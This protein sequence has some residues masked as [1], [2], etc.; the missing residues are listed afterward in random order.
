VILFILSRT[1]STVEKNTYQAKKRPRWRSKSNT[2]AAQG[3]NCG[4]LAENRSAV[5]KL[6]S[7][8]GDFWGAVCGLFVLTAEESI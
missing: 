6:V 8:S 7:V 5:R 4:F 1:D 2:N 3:Q